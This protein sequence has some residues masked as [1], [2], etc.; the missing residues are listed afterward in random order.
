MRTLLED[1]NLSLHLFC[2]LLC[3]NSFVIHHF[4]RYRAAGV[5]VC[6]GLDLAEGAHPQIPLESVVAYGHWHVLYWSPK[7][8]TTIRYNIW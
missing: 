1:C 8:Q 6:R 2:H 5:F 3:F 7:P 4:Y